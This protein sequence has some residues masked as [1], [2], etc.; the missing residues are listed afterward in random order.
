VCKVI[1]V[2]QCNR[3]LKYNIKY[4]VTYCSA[5]DIC[6]CFIQLRRFLDSSGGREGGGGG[7]RER[8]RE[9]FGVEGVIQKR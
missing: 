5:A 9:M 1:L 4:I 3:T 2:H 6:M 8:E 7:E